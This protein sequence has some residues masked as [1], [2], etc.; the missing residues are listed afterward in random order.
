MYEI[1][2]FIRRPRRYTTAIQQVNYPVHKGKPNPFHRKFFF[3]G[4]IPAD[5][6]N[7]EKRQSKFYDSEQ[8]AINAAIEAGATDIQRCDC[9]FVMR[10]GKR[11]A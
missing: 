7:Y 10:N 9:S 2:E 3:V 6:Y 5:C 1:G 11:I 8:K 4:A